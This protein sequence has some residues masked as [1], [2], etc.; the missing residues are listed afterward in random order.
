LT[1]VERIAIRLVYKVMD[2]K[3]DK[4][5]PV[6]Y[7]DLASRLPA[8]KV[9]HHLVNEKLR[10]LL[11]PYGDDPPEYCSFEAGHTRIVF[12]K[13]PNR[14][15]IETLRKALILEGLYT[16]RVRRPESV[17]GNAV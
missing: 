7:E 8:L 12:E 10:E 2:E 3:R 13:Y 9:L 1:A 6:E 5:K 16:P 15:S 17:S 4:D 14:I 11:A